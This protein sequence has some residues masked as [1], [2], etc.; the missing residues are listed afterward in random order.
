MIRSPSQW[1]GTARSAASAGP[2]GDVDHVRD[3]VLALP[4]L[5]ARFPHGP[6]G[7]QTPGQIVF[8]RSAGLHIQRLVDGFGTHL[9]LRLIGELELQPASDLLRGVLLGQVRLHDPTQHQIGGQLRRLR[10]RRPLI[11][12]RVRRRGPVATPFVAVASQLPRH[13]RRRPADRCGDRS[14]RVAA[15][16]GDGDLLP[17]R[18]R[19]TPTL[20]VP[21]APRPDT[22]VGGQPPGGLLAIRSRLSCGVGDELTTLHRRPERLKDLRNHAIRKPFSENGGGGYTLHRT[23]STRFTETVISSAGARW[24]CA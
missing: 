17:L 23:D 15:G 4:R 7:P 14:D 11:S 13:R 8:Q 21:A 12:Q 20:Q 24:A 2:F 19:Q 5:P 1:P 16:P 18:Q 22:T 3:P 9:H 6:P 10:P